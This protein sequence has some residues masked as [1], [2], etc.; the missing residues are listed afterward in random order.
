MFD[1]ALKVVRQYHRI[2]QSDLADRIGI[3]RSYINEIEKGKKEPSIDVLRKYS[4][5]FD[6]PVSSLMLFAERSN[7]SRVDGARTFA[8]DK[9]LKMLEWLSEGI[10]DGDVKRNTNERPK[11]KP[12]K[13]SP[14]RTKVAA[15]AGNSPRHAGG[16]TRTPSRRKSVQRIHA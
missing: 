16:K 2:N 3:S 7:D 1:R 12:R 4:E 5:F 11:D 14:V 15:R 10:D 13:V 6:I 8:A 9:I